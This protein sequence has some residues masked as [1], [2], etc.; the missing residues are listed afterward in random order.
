MLLLAASLIAGTAGA[1]GVVYHSPGDD[2]TDPGMPVVFSGLPGESLYLYADAG[3]VPTA[4]GTA[5][6]DG[7]GD[8]ICAYRFCVEI[9]DFVTI[10]AFYP[11]AA[12]DV[13]ADVSATHLCTTGG[14][15]L[16]GELGPFRIGELVITATGDG[17]VE[18]VEGKVVRADL[19]LDGVAPRVLAV[20]EPSFA[21]QLGVGVGFLIAVAR[22]REVSQ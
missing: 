15:A 13:V 2:G 11:D 7:S 1:A 10:D 12:Q 19:T 3:A 8:E 17:S 16:G 18:V 4:V 9:S 20:P 22:R 6:L 14:N 5:C 21:V